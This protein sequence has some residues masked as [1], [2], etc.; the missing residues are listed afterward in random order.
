MLS[1]IRENVRRYRL[2]NGFSQEA[3][4][5]ECNYD[6]TYIGKIERGDAHPSLEAILRIARVLEIPPIDLFRENG[7]AQLSNE[8][9]R[10]AYDTSETEQLYE[11][12]FENL[13]G[14]VILT[15]SSGEVLHFNESARKFFKANAN[16]LTG[17]PIT[18]IPM[19]GQ[20]GVDR[21]LFEDLVDLGSIG[22]KA[23]RR[24]DMRYKGDVYELQFQVSSIDQMITDESLL[25]FEIIV[26]E[27]TKDRT[28]IGDHSD[29]LQKQDQ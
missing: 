27:A 3:L 7:H 15:D 13:P 10:D 29:L 22:R 1:V 20:V 18:E 6:K 11:K 5:R 28:L 14:L 2:E 8:Q 24:L 9:D 4:S 16:D 12:I 21:D 17:T 26:I 25:I 19:W 23:S